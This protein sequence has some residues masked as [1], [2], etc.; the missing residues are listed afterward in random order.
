M[1]VSHGVRRGIAW[2]LYLIHGSDESIVGRGVI[3]GF[4][5]HTVTLGCCEIYHVCLCG[6]CVDAID[7]DNLHSMALE[8]KVLGSKCSHVDDSEQVSLPGL[9]KRC[10][11]LRVIHERCLRNRLCSSRVLHVD[12]GAE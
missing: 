7:L 4:D 5:E 1:P 6:L 10:Q 12:E 2:G 8:P 3:L 9:D 11:I